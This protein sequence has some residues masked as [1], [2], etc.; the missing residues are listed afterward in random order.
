MENFS[1]KINS[2][3][4]NRLKSVLPS[5]E[6]GS[7]LRIE[8][9]AG[10][11]SGFSVSYKIDNVI[12]PDDVIFKQDNIQVVMNQLLAEFIEDA[13]LY[14]KTDILSSYFYLDVKTATAKCSC[15]SSFAK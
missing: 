5:K 7:F 9:E 12:M 13:E 1:I 14:F 3:A 2:T 11:C 10:G 15:G 4:V 6:A 8:V